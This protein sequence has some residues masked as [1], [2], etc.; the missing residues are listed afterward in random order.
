[1][2]SLR[3]GSPSQAELEKFPANTLFYNRY[4][5]CNF[6]GP[7]LAERSKL[8]IENSYFEVTNPDSNREA[9]AAFLALDEEESHLVGEALAEEE[10]A[11]SSSSSSS[12]RAQK[13][14]KKK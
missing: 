14:R 10:E 1:M 8:I 12:D 11:S 5:M 4:E 9:A 6:Y 3:E 13:R 7:S 2:A